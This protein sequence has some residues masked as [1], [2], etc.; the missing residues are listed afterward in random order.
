MRNTTVISA[1]KAEAVENG[2]FLSVNDE[3]LHT[4][5]ENNKTVLKPIKTV[6]SLLEAGG[7]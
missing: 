4:V 3:S 6:Y 5:Y 2:I 1:A 7:S